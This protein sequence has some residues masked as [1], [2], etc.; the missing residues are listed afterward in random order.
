MERKRKLKLRVNLQ[1][2]EVMGQSS[3]VVGSEI[4]SNDE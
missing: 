4:Q 2:K 3:M 1:A